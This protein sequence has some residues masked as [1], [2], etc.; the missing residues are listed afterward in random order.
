[1]IEVTFR[2]VAEDLPGAVLLAQFERTWPAY[3]AWYLREGEAPRPSYVQCR[4]M[5]RE[6]LPELVPTWE[7]LVE[8]VGGGDL[9]AE[10]ENV[11]QH[12]RDRESVA[13]RVAAAIGQGY[14]EA[15]PVDAVEH[16]PDAIGHRHH[17]G[18]VPGAAQ[19]QAV[20]QAGRVVVVA[21]QGRGTMGT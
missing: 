3:R 8:L 9:A 14:G 11:A 10:F 12:D 19:D 6:H 13:H 15:M 18:A 5:L 7:R 21:D 4:R 16:S 17:G 1:M 20:E 2:A